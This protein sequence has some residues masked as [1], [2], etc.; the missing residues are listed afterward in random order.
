MSPTSYQTAPP[1]D[2][3]ITTESG[4]VKLRVGQQLGRRMKAH[5][6]G[7]KRARTSDFD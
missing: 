5:A 3:M 1:R 4:S 2:L 7:A 6:S